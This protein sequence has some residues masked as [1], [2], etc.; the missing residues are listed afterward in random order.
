MLGPSA[1]FNT[2]CRHGANGDGKEP[3][4]TKRGKEDIA[5]GCHFGRREF[6]L[7]G[8]L[9]EIYATTPH[10][11]PRRLRRLSFVAYIIPR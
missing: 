4:Q 11:K 9:H 1:L 8:A 5:V 6:G 7:R 2:G 3:R 10:F